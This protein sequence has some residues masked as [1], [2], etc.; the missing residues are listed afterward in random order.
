LSEFTAKGF[1][2]NTDQPSG[3]FNRK[4][5]YI[6]DHLQ[7]HMYRFVEIKIRREKR[8]KFESLYDD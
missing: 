1:H 8:L 3:N 4:T 5:R 7:K 2:P 6:V